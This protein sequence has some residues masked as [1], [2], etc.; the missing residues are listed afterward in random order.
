MLVVNHN[1]S[2]CRQPFCVPC[3]MKFHFI[4]HVVVPELQMCGYGAQQK[5]APD[6]SSYWGLRDCKYIGE[7]TTLMLFDTGIDWTHPSFA[8]KGDKLWLLQYKQ[9][10]PCGFDEDGHGTMCAGI[11]CGDEYGKP[12]ICRGVAPGAKLGIWKAYTLN[13]EAGN[14]ANQLAQLIDLI[15]K[16]N[17]SIDVLVIPSGF[18]NPIPELYEYIKKLDCLGVIIVCAGSNEGAVNSNNIAYPARYDETICVGSNDRNGGK[19]SSSPE[20]AAMEFLALGDLVFG[21]KSGQNVAVQQSGTS[22]AASALGG[23]ICLI[24]QVLKL[25]QVGVKLDRQLIVH[26]L[27]LLTNKNGE[28]RD[29]KRGYGA[30]APDKLKH[31]FANPKHFIERLK[32]DNIQRASIQAFFLKPIYI[33]I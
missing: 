19:S 33:Y 7:G 25:C 15:E 4:C 31:F 3:T 6:P 23:L 24:L 2:L 28:P 11:A 9:H 13:G 20:G 8:S 22:F 27:K 32:M 10:Q 14:W 21:P 16:Y 5:N 30:I 17:R 18:D 26:V 1:Y 29:T 12:V